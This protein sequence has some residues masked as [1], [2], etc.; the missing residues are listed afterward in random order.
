MNAGFAPARLGAAF[1]ASLVAHMA[2]LS[3]FGSLPGGRQ[4]TA[5]AQ[6]GEPFFVASLRASVSKD[7][8]P[9]KKNAGVAA[10][11]LPALPTARYYA[12]HELDERPLILTHVEPQFPSA[13][14]PGVGRVTL[15]LYIGE[16]GRV[17]AIDV[18]DAEPTG[19]FEAAAA[20]AFTAAR[21]RPGMRDGAAVKS[22]LML[23]VLFGAAPPA[24]P[25]STR[26]ASGERRPV[27]NANASEAPGRAEI[28]QR[29]PRAKRAVQ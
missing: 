7:D 3:A 6:Y 15:Q 2:L 23:E 13:P 10:P 18:F 1:G 16:E 5:A 25:A 29:T 21:F 17:E 22:T 11:G 26:S 12:A 8:K 24:D 28:K 4:G 19:I 14:T 20:Q 27:A 9:L